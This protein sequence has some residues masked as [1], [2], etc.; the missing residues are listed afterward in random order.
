MLFGYFVFFEPNNIIVLCNGF[1]KK[2]QKTPSKE[3]RKAI[4]IM[5]AYYD[6]KEK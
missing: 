6:E 5:K 3:L 4:K 2:T 1:A